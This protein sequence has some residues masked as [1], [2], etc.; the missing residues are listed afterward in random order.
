MP[1]KSKSIKK[2]SQVDI[3]WYLVSQLRNTNLGG[4]NVGTSNN[5]GPLGLI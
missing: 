5:V 3:T 1:S 2:L 4:L